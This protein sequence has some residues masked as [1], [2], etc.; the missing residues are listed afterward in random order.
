MGNFAGTA[1][2]FAAWGIVFSNQTGAPITGV[3]VSYIGEQWRKGVADAL[4]FSFQITAG[5]FAGMDPSVALPSGWTAEPALDFVAPHLG[6]PP[7]LDGN[8][9][10]NRVALTKTIAVTLPAGQFLAL[11]WRD[12]DDPGSNDAA[13]GIDDL[14]V[15]FA[16]TPVPE[17]SAFV[18]LGVATA[19]VVGRRKLAGRLMGVLRQMRKA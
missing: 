9:A 7:I 3:T 14:T 16:A 4:R 17:S 10:A 11:R 13:L 2:P 19:V 15:S 8:D 12:V 5:P 6:S 18:F 1:N